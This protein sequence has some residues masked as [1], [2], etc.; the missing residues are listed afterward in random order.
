MG[1]RYHERH[2][3]SKRYPDPDYELAGPQV[4]RFEYYYLLSSALSA[5]ALSNGAV[6]NKF[7]GGAWS[8]VN[9]FV[10]TDV[11]AIVVDI[12]AIDPKSKVL[13]S[14]HRSPRWREG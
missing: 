1:C 4:F 3:A 7:S 13:L 9:S 5:D 12:A 11:A 8:N 10:I 14:V 2:T 6:P